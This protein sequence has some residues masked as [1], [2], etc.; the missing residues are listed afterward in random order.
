VLKLPLA[1]TLSVTPRAQNALSNVPVI[2][3]NHN[4]KVS[5]NLPGQTYKTAELTLYSVNGKQIMRSKADPARAVNNIARPNLASGVYLLSVKSA[6]GQSFSNRVT[7]RGGNLNI[8][9]SF[10]NESFLTS[11][12]VAV[13]NDVP[14]TNDWTIVVSASGYIDSSYTLEVVKGDNGLQTIT[15]K[16][17]G[18]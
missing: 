7:H 6:S 13:S 9:V 1:K 17:E 10:G 18:G 8:G 12:P 15:L 16:S 5:L 4:G 2:T 3:G 14:E 11:S